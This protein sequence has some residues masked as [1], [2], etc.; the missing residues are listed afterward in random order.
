[1]TLKFCVIVWLITLVL[2]FTIAYFL[3]FHVD[4]LSCRS[5]CS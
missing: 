5:R 2:G 1:M 3:A 4:S